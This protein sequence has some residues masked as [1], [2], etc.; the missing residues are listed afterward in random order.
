MLSI[1]KRRKLVGGLEAH[2]YTTAETFEEDVLAEAISPFAA[3]EG[4]ESPVVVLPDVS[5][6]ADRISPTGMTLATRGSIV[7]A[8]VP[9]ANGSGVRMAC[10]D[11]DETDL[12]QDRIARFLQ[13]LS[14]RI[15]IYGEDSPSLI[16][17]RLRES[18]LHGI[19]RG[20]VPFLMER[21]GLEESIER[22]ES[23]GRFPVEIE[24]SEEF[25]R[26]VPDY[27]LEQGLHNFGILESGNHFIELQ[28]VDEILNVDLA[29][30]AGLETGRA[31]V[32]IHDGS[33]AS[34]VGQYFHP[35]RYA[36]AR[37]SERFEADKR[38]YHERFRGSSTGDSNPS[39]AGPDSRFFAPS[40][41]YYS[42][43]EG[44]PAHRRFMALMG[45][46]C[47]F[48]LAN[49]A[50]LQHIVEDTLRT[51]F[52]RPE[53]RCRT[54]T[55]TLHDCVKRVEI[56]QQSFMVH[57]HGAS[58][59]RPASTYGT[60]HPFSQT[61]QMLAIPGAPGRPSFLAAAVDTDP[62]WHSSNHGA[63]RKVDRGIARARFEEAASIAAVRES[64]AALLRGGL[65]SFSGEHPEA[66]KEGA[67]VLGLAEEA[68]ILRGV[69]R[70]RPVAIYKG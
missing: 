36:K 50:Y 49:R 35:C 55:D 29:R 45:M 69:A 17:G 18:D 39:E 25:R 10:L 42:I 4:V 60:D 57:R 67:E 15:P 14:A 66:Y 1:P 61:G 53:I 52:G 70:L 64:G 6:K 23:G 58:E 56:D 48:G 30:A 65:A 37:E 28:I 63:G 33:P 59:A 21:L 38:A 54:L 51:L 68:D 47:N 20:G 31:I 5:H 24:S 62:T 34:L 22:I 8:A 2:Y 7:P 12:N 27:F 44:T 11:L 16:R 32:M 46:A 3:I 43:E 19:Y 13:V 9:A 41:P 40:S 26:F